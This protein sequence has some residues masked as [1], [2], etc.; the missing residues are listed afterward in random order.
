MLLVFPKLEPIQ[1]TQN[2]TKFTTESVDAEIVEYMNKLT[3]ELAC[4]L[5]S[6]GAILRPII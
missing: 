3:S 6:L 4:V 2:T 1:F 5:R